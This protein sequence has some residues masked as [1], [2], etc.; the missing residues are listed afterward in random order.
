MYYT[1]AVLSLTVL[2]SLLGGCGQTGPLYLPEKDEEKPTTER[3]S[4]ISSQPATDPEQQPSDSSQS[5][6]DS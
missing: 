6:A 2:L 1:A 3:S 4:E 5:A